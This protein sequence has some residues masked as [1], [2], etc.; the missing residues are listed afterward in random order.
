MIGI[1]ILTHGNLGHALLES[2]HML[3][4]EDLLQ[5]KAISIDVTLDPV[6]AHQTV[7][8]TVKQLETGDGVLILTDMFGGTP[9]DLGFSFLEEG[10]VEVVTGVNLP[11]LFKAID[12]RHKASLSSLAET[13]EAVGRTSICRGSKILKGNKTATPKS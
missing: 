7:G 3:T 11:I 9:S 10:R 1:I 8:Q 13:I 5:V 6:K 2:L 12:G 4:K